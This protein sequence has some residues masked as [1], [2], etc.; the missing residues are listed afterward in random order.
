LEKIS[1]SLKGAIIG[2]PSDFLD[3]FLDL[4]AVFLSDFPSKREKLREIPL[5]EMIGKSK[6]VVVGKVVRIAEVAT[7]KN[8]KKS[9]FDEMAV[10]RVE[11]EQI[12]VGSYEDK[13]IDITFYPRLTFEAHFWI[14]E[15]C[16]FLIDERN[17]IV[18]G[19]AGKIPIEKDNV[20]VRYILGEQKSQTFKDFINRIKD[21]KSK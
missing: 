8:A 1:F 10:A 4:L 3:H 2:M 13:H 11:I 12:I 7:A 17:H 9:I 15:R 20:E 21:S 5:D 16:I 14:N 19:Y 6:L 18:Q